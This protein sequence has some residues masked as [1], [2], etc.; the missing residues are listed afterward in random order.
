MKNKNFILVL[1]LCVIIIA[2]AVYTIL[3]PHDRQSEKQLTPESN[4]LPKTEKE[5]YPPSYIGV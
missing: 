2:I 1:S 3:L 5:Q 4:K